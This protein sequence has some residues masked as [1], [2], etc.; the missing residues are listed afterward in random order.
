MKVEAEVA[1]VR[2]KAEGGDA[3]AMRM[4]GFAYRDGTQGLK[5]DRKQAFMWLKR[6][7]DL[8]DM[9]AL[10][11]CGVDYLYGQGVER[12]VGRGLVML[13][14][15]AEQGSE[16]ACGLL[17]CANAEGEYGFDKDE[18]EATRWYREMQKRGQL[19]SNPTYRERAAAWLREHP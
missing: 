9:N 14:R 3:R 7:A 19:D 16:H 17:G 5:Q 1:A 10:A 2:A 18:Q 6:A 15:A 12:S 11:Q 8:R 4:L 13:G